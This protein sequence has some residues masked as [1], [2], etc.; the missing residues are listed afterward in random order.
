VGAPAGLHQENC[1]RMIRMLRDTH[2]HTHTR[3][4]TAG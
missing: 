1:M 3:M 4:H 2:T